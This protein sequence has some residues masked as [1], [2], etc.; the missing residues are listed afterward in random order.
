MKEQ[1]RP[2]T[3]LLESEGSPVSAKKGGAE[4]WLALRESIREK[5]LV[6]KQL[7]NMNLHGHSL[8]GSSAGEK[9]VSA[10]MPGRRVI[11]FG[12]HGFYFEDSVKKEQE[13]KL[14]ASLANKL[15]EGL[16]MVGETD[17]LWRGGLVLAGANRKESL[18]V[19]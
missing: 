17:P 7:A 10:L 3:K 15:S 2:Q 6:E 13:K 14:S 12:T 5:E 9:V 11:Y 19:S 16:S 4:K 1:L 8:S 18:P